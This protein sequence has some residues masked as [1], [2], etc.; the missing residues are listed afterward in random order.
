MDLVHAQVLARRRRQRFTFAAA[1]LALYFLYSLQWVFD[2]S[3]A[4]AQGDLPRYFPII[5]F[6]VLIIAMCALE[7]VHFYIE[8]HHHDHDGDLGAE[9]ASGLPSSAPTAGPGTDSG[10]DN[11]GGDGS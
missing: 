11:G 10:G 7:F 5:V 1:S 4:M 6:Y 9:D 3:G 2:V 8:D